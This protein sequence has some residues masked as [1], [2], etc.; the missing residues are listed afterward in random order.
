MPDFK[1]KKPSELWFKTEMTHRQFKA[2]AHKLNNADIESELI[3]LNYFTERLS[4][5]KNL[6]LQIV[7]MWLKNSWN[8][9]NVLFHTNSIIQGTGESF[10]MQWAFPQAYFS[11]YCSILAYFK[12]VGFTQTSHNGVLKEFGN[13]IRQDKYPQSISMYTSESKQ[14]IQYNNIT[15]HDSASTIEF[16]LNRP[17]TIDNQICQFLKSTRELML[18]DKAPKMKFK[19]KAGKSRQKLTPDLWEKVS[20]KIGYT[21]IMD[22]LYR[23]RIK[24][25]Y[26]DIDTFNAE[27]FKGE[28]VL[29]DLCCVVDHLNLI[30]E[31]YI[32]KAIGLNEY[33]KML[34]RHLKTVKNERAKHRFETIK[35]IIGKVS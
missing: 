30:N 27:E 9:E 13:L 10:A 8:T 4:G 32:A 21:T 25:N 34:N 12:S 26:L 19:T 1:R 35:T 16:D 29:K 24:A 5:A 33:E 28:E 20:D 3:N 14:N 22:F 17:K 23:K 11:T 2:L 18:Y 6:D 7:E 31:T 15:K